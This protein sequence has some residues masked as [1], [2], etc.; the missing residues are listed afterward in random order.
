MHLQSHLRG[1]PPSG[2]DGDPRRSNTHA[3]ASPRSIEVRYR[4]APSSLDSRASREINVINPA[5][6]SAAA[7]LTC[8]AKDLRRSSRPSRTR[9]RAKA[10]R[11]RACCATMSGWNS[12][13]TGTRGMATVLSPY[14]V[15]GDGRIDL[16]YLQG[17][18]S[19]VILNWEHPACA[20]FQPQLADLSRSWSASRPTGD[21]ATASAGSSPPHFRALVLPLVGAGGGP[22]GGA[23]PR[24]APRRPR[25][26]RELPQHG[27]G[28]ARLSLAIT[29]EVLEAGLARL[30]AAFA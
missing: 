30:Q 11:P 14:Q 21:G 17:F 16:V 29:D 1:S 7:S 8:D 26:R 3:S 28:W 23:A 4:V 13:R 19:N 5:R 18:P 9:E 15:V 10:W 24:R 22:H 27:A 20:R 2:S 25:A 12:R 6:A